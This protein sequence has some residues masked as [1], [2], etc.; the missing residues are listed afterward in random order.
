VTPIPDGEYRLVTYRAGSQPIAGVLVG[1]RVHPASEL[2]SRDGAID[3][4]TVL[5]L[6]ATWPASH[7]AIVAALRDLSP[8]GGSGIDEVSLLAPILYPGTILC[9]GANYWDHV[10]EMEGTI[11]RANRPKEP[12]FFVKTSANTV[13]AHQTAVRPPTAQLDWEAELAVVIGTHAR[14][15]PAERAAEVIA[16]YTI[17]N[18]L[19]AR[20]LM[21]RSDRPASMTFD[22]VGQKCFDGSAPM[23]PWITPAEFIEDCHD[24]AVRLWVNDVL[25]QDSHTSQLVHDVYEQ[26]EWLTHHLTLFPGD[27]IA[28]GTPSGVGM[29]RGEFLGSGDVVRIQIDGCGELVTPIA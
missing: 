6:L 29:P 27:V 26:I 21:T 3:S 10:E 22:W 7:E 20:D 19:S 12:W 14:D 24:L 8:T 4:S 9:T 17:V 1:D 16:G 11:D 2:L 28:T 5:G 13:V 18:D 25:K 15:V 23:G